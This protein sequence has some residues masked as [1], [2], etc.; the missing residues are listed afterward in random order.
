MTDRYNALTVVLEK[1]IRDDDAEVL[2]AAIRQ[3]RGV[4]SVS[5]NV[6]EPI[7]YI[8]QQRARHELGEKLWHVLYPKREG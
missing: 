3:L 7:D 4:L 2:L 1:D 8:A 6:A 5:G